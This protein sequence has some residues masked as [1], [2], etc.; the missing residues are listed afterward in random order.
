MNK[1]PLNRYKVSWTEV[2]TIVREATTW[3]TAQS[4]TE[5]K[6]IAAKKNAKSEMLNDWTVKNYN[7][8]YCGKMLPIARKSK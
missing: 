1:K 6:Q 8:T 2:K 3:I 7:A 5:A 4:K